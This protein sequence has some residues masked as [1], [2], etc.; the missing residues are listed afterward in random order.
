MV[1]STHQTRKWLGLGA[2]LLAVLAFIVLGPLRNQSS[3]TPDDVEAMLNDGAV[4][5]AQVAFYDQIGEDYPDEYANFLTD[6]A[7]TFNARGDVNDAAAFELGV[8][9]TQGLRRENAKFIKTAPADAL[10]DMNYGML[11]LLAQLQEFPEICGLFAIYGGAGLSFDQ[12]QKLDMNTMA[13]VSA[14]TFAAM[15]AGRDTPVIHPETSDADIV[16]ALS[17]WQQ[18]PDVSADMIRALT[19]GDPQHPAQCAA[20]LSFQRFVTEADDPVIVRA[21]IRLVTL[22]T[23]I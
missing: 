3:M 1:T 10:R 11:G 20:Q 13:S 9:F 12:V 4:V 17:V 22:S 21:M 18:K 15:A 19:L 6:M 2:L 5:P 7:D 23:G 14:T 8:A 16:H